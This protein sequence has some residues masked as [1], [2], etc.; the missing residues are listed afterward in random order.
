MFNSATSFSCCADE[1]TVSVTGAAG[2]VDRSGA[3]GTSD[4][5]DDRDLPDDGI[6]VTSST[7]LVDFSMLSM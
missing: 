4:L 3:G 1:A 6:S 7:L 5:V 2:F